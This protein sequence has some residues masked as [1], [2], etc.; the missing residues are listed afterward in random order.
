VN[1]EPTMLFLVVCSLVVLPC[2][3]GTGRESVTSGL[4]KYE[5]LGNLH[6]PNR[7]LASIF[8]ILI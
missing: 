1:P 2:Q 5:I 7:S 8:L 4:A 6:R 3:A